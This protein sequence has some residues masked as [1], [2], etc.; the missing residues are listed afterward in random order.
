M[1]PVKCNQPGCGG[2]IDGGFCDRCGLEPTGGAAVDPR[3]SVVSA[4]V[5]VASRGSATLGSA[6][7]GSAAHGSA[8]LGSATLGSA[9]LGSSATGRAGSTGSRRGSGSVR[10]TTRKHLGLGL[11]T[12]PGLPAIDPAAVVMADAGVPPHKRFCPNPDCHDDAGGPTPLARRLQGHCPQCGTA[13]SFVPTLKAGDVVADQY[14]VA[15]P[16]AYGGLGWIYLATDRAL[17][18]WVVLKGLLNSGDAGAAAAAVAERQ[19]LASVKHANIVGVYNFAKRAAEGFIVMEYVGGRTLKDVRKGRGPLPPGEAIA[20]VHRILGA[21]AYLHERRL[22]Y[23]DFKPDNVMVEGDPPD[24][25]LIDM[26]GVRLIDDPAGDIYGTQGYMAP[27]A[28]DGPTVQSD[29]YTVGRTLAVLLMDFRFQS[30]FEHALPPPAEQPVLAAHESLQRFLARAT[31]RDPDRRF[32]SADEM[33]DQLAGVLRE[34][35]AGTV[36]AKPV[37][38]ALFGGD[39]MAAG[40]PDAADVDRVPAVKLD[41]DDPGA[42]AVLTALTVADR[43]RQ[44]EL[45]AAGLA[46]Q[47]ASA[48]LRLRLAGVLVRLGQ[49][50]Q[51]DRRLAEAAAA[52][53]LD[54]RPHWYGGLLL[55]ARGEPH[56]ARGLFDRVYA[57]L[58]G[59]PAVKLAVAVAAERAGDD[60]VAA[61]LFDLVGRTDPTFASAAFGLA[62]CL[63]RGGRRADAAAALRRVPVSSSLY[64]PAQVALARLLV[65]P[66]PAP[67]AAA[68]LCEASAVVDSLGL[69]GA[70]AARLRT[71]VLDQALSLL[72]S[73]AVAADPDRLL[74]GSP[75]AER[76][77]RLGLERSLR[78][79]ARHEPDRGKQIGLV[80][81]AN[82]VRPR[83]LV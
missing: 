79:L 67:P 9:T 2:T 4:S 64:T 15:G 16:I 80:D 8:T 7:L 51:A 33:A 29:L 57:D 60:A 5:G 75:L 17:S 71:E 77:V 42:A 55:L 20:Y 12:V 37:D 76:P 23:C 73:R 58:P 59:E 54:W 44:A 25:K 63:A 13:Y 22:V 66:T 74:F 46:A 56:L 30:V 47:P 10:T 65:D 52:D 34:V 69:D 36:P 39:P 32:A 38:S 50:P 78:Q 27:E 62:R 72:Q 11:V 61:R 68:D 82:R 1:N 28:K 49:F 83:T 35:V 45:L 70:E 3:P 81:R 31:H 19:F 21:F 41:P 14:E 26:G 43:D 6:T 18:R 40:E 24:V 48:E 53:P